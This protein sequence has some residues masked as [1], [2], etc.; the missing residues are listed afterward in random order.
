MSDFV[1]RDDGMWMIYSD[2]GIRCAYI[3][4][5]VHKKWVKTALRRFIWRHI[6]RRFT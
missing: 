2:G 4:A 3:P 6:V 5:Y 1:M